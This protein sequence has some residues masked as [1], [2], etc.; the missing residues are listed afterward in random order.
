PAERQ[1]DALVRAAMLRTKSSLDYRRAIEHLE[2]AV[3]R[4][5]AAG[6]DAALG[7]VHSRIGGVLCTHHSVM[8]IPRAIEHFAAAQRLLAEPGAVFH[9]HRGMVQAAMY[10]L[11]TETLGTYAQRAYEL[12]T[13]LQ[14]RDL[15]VFA[16]WGR[17]WHLF[18]RGELA[19]A[20]ASHETMWQTARE[21][22][23]P[24]LGWMSVNPAALC[25]TGYR[26]DPSAARIWCRRGLAQARFDTFTYPHD[27][28]VD[29]LA[30]AMAATGELEA[31]RRTAEPLPA[32][33]VSRRLLTF[34][35][36]DWDQAERS[37]AGALH[38][39]ESAGDLHDAALNCRWLADARLQL[40]RVAG[41]VAAL[42]RALTLGVD[43]PQVP[44][45][46]AARA[47]L[48][49]V[50]ASAGRVEEADGH[51]AR[52]EEILALGEDWGGQAGGVELAR[53]AVFAAHG[54]RDR[55]DAAH[56]RALEVFT[57][58]KL[59]WQR[60]DALHG[61]ARLLLAAGYADDAAAKHRASWD[62]YD[63]I[64]AARQ[65]R[66]PLTER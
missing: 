21:L 10:G 51:L 54:K 45:E 41:A 47:Q 19:A 61:W 15:T 59:P 37:W 7:S 65:W 33:A 30:L 52:C 28:V 60:A 27:A 25:A 63:E 38:A 24:Y 1:A 36:G 23:D 55:S 11:R 58:Y 12:S 18:N 5:R 6:D 3:E 66:R 50:L 13:D 48:A 64:G 53:G 57:A 46:L 62:V 43:G 8:D 39:D 49:R 40:G 2:A 17:A 14:R 26:L 42:H 4:Y 20:S 35:D 32:D 34:L 44:T 31:A 9:L 22:G 16:G 29:Q 56:E